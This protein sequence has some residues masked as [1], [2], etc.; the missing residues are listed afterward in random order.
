[1]LPSSEILYHCTCLKFLTTLFEHFVKR[2]KIVLVEECRLSIYM[3]GRRLLTSIFKIYIKFPFSWY[4]M[5]LVANMSNIFDLSHGLK[6]QWS[7][8]K[9]IQKLICNWRNSTLQKLKG[10]FKERFD[11]AVSEGINNRDKL[12]RKFKNREYLLTRKTIKKPATKLRN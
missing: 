5:C 10:N 11:R 1:M 4:I 2:R 3:T 7:L 12:F 6:Y 9:L 8:F